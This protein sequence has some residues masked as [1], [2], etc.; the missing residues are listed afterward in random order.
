M[1]NKKLQGITIEI[2]GNTTKLNDAISKMNSA[3]SNANSELKSLNNSE[4]PILMTHYVDENGYYLV[5][6]LGDLDKVEIVTVD[7]FSSILLNLI[8]M[9]VGGVICNKLKE[10]FI[11]I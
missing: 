10:R 5:Y 1:A 4:L 6:Y 9:V 2:D 7:L 11:I 3:I 8:S